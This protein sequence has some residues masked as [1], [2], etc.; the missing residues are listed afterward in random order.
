MSSTQ[1]TVLQT[2]A[3]DASLVVSD[4]LS[5]V[6]QMSQSE[7]D[8]MINELDT[9]EQTEQTAGRC[10]CIPFGEVWRHSFDH[11]VSPVPRVVKASHEKEVQ[12]LSRQLLYQSGTGVA[13]EQVA[14][15]IDTPLIVCVEGNFRA[16]PKSRFHCECNHCEVCF[17]N[18]VVALRSLMFPSEK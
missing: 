4:V 1:K 5:L 10:D 8:Q 16:S 7:F 13:I 15:R 17:H 11:Y 6:D 2:P 12:Q 18:N 3:C 14:R 9:L